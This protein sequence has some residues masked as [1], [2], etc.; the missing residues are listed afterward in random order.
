M[1]K[2]RPAKQDD[3]DVDDL[4]LKVDLKLVEDSLREISEI[5]SINNEARGSE[6][7]SLKSR[8]NELNSEFVEAQSTKPKIEFAKVD[9]DLIFNR[10]LQIGI[11]KNLACQS[12]SWLNDPVNM[13]AACNEAISLAEAMTEHLIRRYEV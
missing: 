4:A 1:A 7:E 12:S 13:R 8:I 5:Q 2:S 9:P 3:I 10:C 6:I 11:D